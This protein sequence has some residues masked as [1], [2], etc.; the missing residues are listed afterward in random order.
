MDL[1]PVADGRGAGDRGGGGVAVKII[2]RPTPTWHCAFTC[3][4]CRAELEAD[5]NDVIHHPGG[6]EN[7]GERWEER[8][9]LRCLACRHVHEVASARLSEPVK[10]FIRSRCAEADRKAYYD[11]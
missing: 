1:R 4:R 11:R 5:Q 7:G 9:E 8:F 6:Q 3:E 2:N 10:L